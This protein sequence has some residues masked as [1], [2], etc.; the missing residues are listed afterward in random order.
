MHSHDINVA[1]HDPLSDPHTIRNA[2]QSQFARPKPG[3]LQLFWETFGR[4]PIIQL[5]G[6]YLS[7]R[8][9][10]FDCSE[11]FD[12]SAAAYS[13]AAEAL[14]N[15]YFQVN[16]RQRRYPVCTDP[17]SHH[18]KYSIDDIDLVI[19][20]HA[21]LDLDQQGPLDWK[22]PEIVNARIKEGRKAIELAIERGVPRPTCII[23]TG[24]GLACL[25]KFKEPI[26][27][28]LAYPTV[29]W[30]GYAVGCELIRPLKDGKPGPEL[31]RH[32]WCEPKAGQ[33]RQ[34]QKVQ[35][36]MGA[37]C[38]LYAIMY[39]GDVE[40]RKT[41][42]L[43]LIRKLTGLNLALLLALAPGDEL[44]RQG[45]T[46]DLSRLL[47]LPDSVN[48]PNKAKIER[49]R[50]PALSSV[51]WL[52]PELVYSLD[53]FRN[54]PEIV[55]KFRPQELMAVDVNAAAAMG[56]SGANGEYREG[57]L[58][59]LQA[60]LNFIDPDGLNWRKHTAALKHAYDFGDWPPEV[61]ELWDEWS[62]RG[63]KYNPGENEKCWDSW[64]HPEGVTIASIFW[65]AKQKGYNIAAGRREL[66][67]AAV[68][69]R[70]EACL[71]DA[72]ELEE[73][74]AGS[75][76]AG[77]PAKGM[78][79]VQAALAPL[80]YQA[81]PQHLPEPEPLPNALPPVLPF[82]FDLLPDP[83]QRY[84]R[85]SQ[86]RKQ[87]IPDFLGISAMITL[88]A[89]IGP[90][91]TIRPLTN[92][93]WTEAANNF[94]LGI[95]SSGYMKSAAIDDFV[96]FL[97]QLEGEARDRHKDA[98]AAYEVKKKVAEAKE[99]ALARKLAADAKEHSEEE[100][101]ATLEANMPSLGD[102]PTAKRYLANNVNPA[103]LCKLLRQNPDGVLL[104]RDEMA[105]LLNSLERED[106]A[107]LRQI[108]IEGHKGL[109][110]FTSD[111]IGQGLD[112]HIPSLCV[113][114]L[115]TIQPGVIAPYIRAALNEGRGADGFLQRFQF[116][117]WP[118][119]P[120]NW[121]LVDRKR[122]AKLCEEAFQAY[123]TLDRLTPADCA[124][125]CDNFGGKRPYLHFD[126]EAQ[127]AFNTWYSQHNIELRSKGVL[128]PLDS[129]FAKYTKLIPSLALIIHLAEG[130]RGPV[131][132]KALQKA[133]GWKRFLESHAR[134]IYGSGQTASVYA[135]QAILAKIKEGKLTSGFTLRKIQEAGW[136][137]LGTNEIVNDALEL[138]CER[139]W[140][141]SNK[142]ETG[143][144][145]KFVYQLNPKAKAHL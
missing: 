123:R 145:P 10:E 68:E 55:A 112:L 128:S 30:A 51:V 62:Q 73:P 81:A 101:A 21:D 8:L 32:V 126:P 125:G 37:L 5:P 23:F 22:K 96:N 113:S 130:G 117:V 54:V 35:E 34:S 124:C 75:G 89:V 82:D 139:G 88:G 18:K 83:L 110:S 15:I 135:A 24:G 71:D 140:L 86:E 59:R 58:K 137:S 69:N 19:A 85:D 143:G 108:L 122:D 98:S 134:R 78:S 72:E 36:E 105:A 102:A 42:R 116:M 9:P 6:V 142:Q 132:L 44:G 56:A 14:E 115:G 31:R 41:Q 60:A 87:C 106:T 40:E 63:T 92:S 17:G 43:E 28:P 7:H 46:S 20:L 103:S 11:L 109:G 50:V 27:L 79:G 47:R 77:T 90:K 138:L 99:K 25:W 119:L 4:P 39:F 94:G 97:K 67:M 91:I 26:P 65:E 93:E 1:A 144:R 84:A 136:S 48:M 118:D 111:R 104:F 38:S 131:G 16:R 3:E 70:Y 29:R 61:K 64:R 127:E 80:P 107:E 129:H 74:L 45:N 33:D 49:G 120:K 95:G 53:D 52:N 76:P 114:L 133:F 141:L 57:D 100:L 66:D 12:K 13:G 2:G 121:K